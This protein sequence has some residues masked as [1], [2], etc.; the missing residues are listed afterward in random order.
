MTDQKPTPE[1]QEAALGALGEE[2][3]ESL[4][5]LLQ[6]LV[7]NVKFIVGTIVA[8][9]LAVGG[10]AIFDS[11]QASKVADAQNELLTIANEQDASKRAEGLQAFLSKA[12]SGMQPGIK[13]E[14][15]TTLSEAGKHQ[16]SATVWGEIAAANTADMGLIAK[17]GRAAELS[18][19]GDH[20][21]AM[22]LLNGIA[23]DASKSY[24]PM[25]LHRLAYEAEM[26]N[27]WNVALSAWEELLTVNSAGSN[28]FIESKIASARAKAQG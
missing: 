23:K 19:S 13:L 5:P 17:A 6:A 18:L 24:K 28:A 12:P 14:L 11:V 10:Y 3:D 20:K 22:D 25:L 1:Q 7:D 21:A 9:I 8:L 15:A 16:E 26:A 2:V 4:H 27:D